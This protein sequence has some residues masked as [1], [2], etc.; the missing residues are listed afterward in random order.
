MKRALQFSWEARNSLKKGI[1]LAARTVGISYGPTGRNILV[2][3]K[4]EKPEVIKS[5]SKV[6]K[7]LSRKDHYEDIG[8]KILREVSTKT[9]KE[10]GDGT[11]TAALLTAALIRNGIKLLHGG[12][13]VSDLQTGLDHGLEV[14]CRNLKKNARDI[15]QNGH[16][17]DKLTHTATY[18]DE[19][20]SRILM[21]AFEKTGYESLITTEEGKSTDT[22]LE[23]KEGM[24]FDRGY[25]SLYFIT[26]L[27]KMEIELEN[28]YILLYNEAISEVKD[29][30]PLLEKCHNESRP[31]LIVAQNVE[32]Y[33]LTTLILNKIRGTLKVAV[34]KAPSF[35]DARLDFLEDIAAYCGGILFTKEK[36]VLLSFI[37]KGMLGEAEKVI[38]DQN[39]TYI[40]NG[41]GSK[42]KLNERIKQIRYTLSKPVTKYNRQKLE[43]RLS[44]LTGS[45]AVIKVGA[46]TESEMKEKKNRVE[47]AINTIRAA[48]EEGITYG[49]GL[50]Y[51][52]TIPELQELEK[53]EVIQD[54]AYGMS[55]LTQALKEPAKVLIN[56]SGA[57]AIPIVEKLTLQTNGIGYDVVAH[58]EVDLIEAGI[59]DP[60]KVLRVALENAVSVAGMFLRTES[61]VSYAK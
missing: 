58:R 57:E 39:N 12:V 23:I 9:Q 4:Y 8:V 7:S 31:L 29:I 21:E 33:A 54:V 34:V 37:E 3:N 20:L 13:N 53:K 41:K 32:S 36:G 35:G 61:V 24:Q 11:T 49:G 30:L 50:A 26:D 22:Q 15:R 38:V 45:V 14:V 10:T 6:L 47:A 46:H 2:H 18:H 1:D 17:L 28:P 55:I 5:G 42:K 52:K 27:S 43:E 25:L 51:L 44:K 60:V 16:F 59:I 48:F 19:A 56:N 40:I